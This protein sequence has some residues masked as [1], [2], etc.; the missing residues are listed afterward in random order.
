MVSGWTRIT[1]ET[2]L[3]KIL[4][5]FAAALL[6]L[7]LVSGCGGSSGGGSSSGGIFY[8]PDNLIENPTGPTR[9]GSYEAVD[10]NG[11]LE[12]ID[13]KPVVRLFGTTWCPHCAFLSDMFDKVAKEYVAKGKIASHHW[14][15]DTGDDTLT[16]E[17][18]WSVP[19]SEEAVWK[20]FNPSGSIPTIVV[21]SKYYRVGTRYEGVS[22][23]IELE[24]QELRAVIDEAVRQAP[25]PP[26][27][28]TVAAT[29]VK[30]DGATL[31][32][33]VNPDG[34]ETAAWFEWAEDSSFTVYDVTAEQAVGSGSADQN[35]DAV[36]TGLSPET[37]YYFRI[38]AKSGQAE[39]RGDVES[40]TT[41]PQ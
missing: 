41:A 37:T 4:S 32:G 35:L 17:T 38:A 31:N 25:L 12:T 11:P 6:C 19:L 2:V 23:G 26:T 39:A 3:K 36:L 14:Q 10:A 30:S 16:D 9:V 24:E 21:G 1:E 34:R 18:E 40:F 15:V 33:V 27:V 22:N 8:P 28:L 20:A 13:G 29:E 7:A 5:G